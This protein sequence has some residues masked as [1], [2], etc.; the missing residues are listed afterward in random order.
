MTP[1]EARRIRAL[2]AAN[3]QS[4]FAILGAEKAITEAIL[5]TPGQLQQAVKAYNEVDASHLPIPECSWECVMNGHQECTKAIDLR[6]AYRFAIAL[7]A[8][9]LV[10]EQEEEE[11]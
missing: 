11:P 2:A 5:I 7:H 6:I 9:G 1:G 10:V 4:G 3:V 8:L